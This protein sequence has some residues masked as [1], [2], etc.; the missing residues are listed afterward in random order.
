MKKVA[1]LLV[2]LMVGAGFAAT[3]EWTFMVLVNGDNNLEKFGYDDIDEMEKVGSTDKVNIVVMFDRANGYYTGDGDWKGAKIFHIQKGDKP[4]V[5]ESTLLKDLGEVDC[6][7]WHTV[8]DFVKFA[9]KKFPAKKYALII[10]NHGGGWKKKEEVNVTKGLSYDDE[11]GNHISTWEM[12]DMMKAIDDVLGKKL[13]LFGM[14]ACLMGAIEVAYEIKDY[15][16]VMVASEKTEPGDGWP[17]DDFLA[18]FVAKPEM[19]AKEL[20]VLIAKKYVESYD[21]GSQGNSAAT[22]AAIDLAKMVE[23]R[24]ALDVFAEA[25]M[26]DPNKAALQRSMKNAYGFGGWFS[27]DYKDIAA[28]VDAAAST[29][30]ASKAVKEAAEKVKVALKDAVLWAGETRR[31]GHKTC[32]LTIWFPGNSSGSMTNYAKIKLAKD[33]KWDDMLHYLYGKKIEMEE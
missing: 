12:A 21:G 19:D 10:W 15:V 23:L 4:F 7:N 33:G 25:V 8:V 17:Y 28:L 20:G 13:D 22:Q 27:S 32:G 30:S 29:A 6:G 18:P 2:L 3:A 31:L 9:A 11:S 24:K 14:D 1:L 5:I 16:D 26:N